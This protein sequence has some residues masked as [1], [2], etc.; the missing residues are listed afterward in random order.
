MDMG[1]ESKFLTPGVL[2]GEE[3][4][5]RADVSGVASDFEKSFGTGAEQQIV[6]DF[7]ILQDQWRELRRKRED[8]M[9]VARRKKFS[10]TCGDPAFAGRG[11]TL[12]AVSIPPA[13]VGAGVTSPPPPPS[14]TIPTTSP[15]AH[16]PTPNP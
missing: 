8:H 14:F 4:E 1:M 3:A 10:L 9:D 12:W 2:H 11:L 5:F 15:A 13:V 7:L 16:A 6:D